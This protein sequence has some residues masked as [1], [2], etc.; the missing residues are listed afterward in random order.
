MGS[1][2]IRGLKA[3]MGR[4]WCISRGGGPNRTVEVYKLDESEEEVTMLSP[5]K[6]GMQQGEAPGVRAAKSSEFSKGE[7]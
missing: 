3:R 2:R 1:R 7:W 5:E 4:K 6:T